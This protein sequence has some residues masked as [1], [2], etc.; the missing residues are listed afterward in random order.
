MSWFWT[1]KV[2]TVEELVECKKMEVA[3]LVVEY[4]SKIADLS[5]ENQVLR[6]VI[7]KK[8]APALNVGPLREKIVAQAKIHTDMVKTIDGYRRRINQLE[9]HHKRI[10]D[11]CLLSE[12]A[13]CENVN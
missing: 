10:H 2:W 3:R 8:E 4:Q 11:N 5:K 6:S 1:P 12:E 9:D 7:T 13:Y